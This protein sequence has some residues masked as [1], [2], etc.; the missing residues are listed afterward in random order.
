MEKNQ[1]VLVGNMQHNCRIVQF[2]TATKAVFFSKCPDWLTC[3]YCQGKE[4]RNNT[5]TFPYVIMAHIGTP[6][7]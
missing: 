1:N 2:L 3:T 6:F 4:T 7:Y 5:S